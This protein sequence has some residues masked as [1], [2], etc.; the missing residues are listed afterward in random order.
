MKYY[1][2]EMIPHTLAYE[3]TVFNSNGTAELS[4]YI[5]ANLVEGYCR[6]LDDL[7]YVC[8]SVWTD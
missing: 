8:P 3:V 4:N 1:T 7:G 2:I 6:C 5:H